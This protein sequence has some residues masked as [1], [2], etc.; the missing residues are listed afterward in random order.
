MGRKIGA[1]GLLNS[2]VSN[3][4]EFKYLWVEKVRNQSEKLCLTFTKSSS[5]VEFVREAILR[6]AV[7]RGAGAVRSG[8]FVEVIVFYLYRGGEGGHAT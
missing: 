2:S 8:V 1:R 7:I 4:V 3:M 5:F 6:G